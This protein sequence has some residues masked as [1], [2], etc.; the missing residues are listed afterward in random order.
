MNVPAKTVLFRTETLVVH[1]YLQAGRHS[2]SSSRQSQHFE[3]ADKFATEELTN[4]PAPSQ[5]TE[6]AIFVPELPFILSVDILLSLATQLQIQQEV[7]AQELI[8]WWMMLP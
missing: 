6:E 3:P 5:P 1:L 2:R 8:F 4:A 7:Q